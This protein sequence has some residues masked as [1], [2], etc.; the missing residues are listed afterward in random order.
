MEGAT[1]P[2][3]YPPKKE[4]IPPLAKA[5]LVIFLGPPILAACIALMI[6]L[7]VY[8]NKP[9]AASASA[10]AATAVESGTNVPLSGTPPAG[11]PVTPTPEQTAAAAAAAAITYTFYQGMESGGNDLQQITAADL[12]AMKLWCSNN[13]DCKGFNTD[14]WAKKLI[15]PFKSW[16]RAFPNVPANSTK[17]IYVKDNPLYVKPGYTFHRGKVSAGGEYLNLKEPN[18]N[19]YLSAACAEDS[20]C[21]AYRTDG[22]LINTVKPPAQWEIPPAWNSGAA[23]DAINGM[24]LRN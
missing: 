11:S 8:V 1:V 7:F 2:M 5:A 15:V 4:G 13:P 17:G 18:N 20:N 19:D 10:T 12:P 16:T 14:G 6:M 3:A 23:S 22:W 24:Y 21:K 9:D